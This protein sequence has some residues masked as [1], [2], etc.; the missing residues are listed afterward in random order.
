M[1]AISFFSEDIEF[2]LSKPRKTVAWLKEVI[3]IEGGT[4]SNLNFIFCSDS[5]LHSLNI[6]YL[7]HTT[8]TDIITF[9][10]AENE[11]EIEGDIFISIERV[12]ENAK[13]FDVSFE[14]ELHRVLVHGV[15][16]LLGYNDKTQAQKRAMRQKE[17]SHLSLP[18]VPRET[19]DT[20]K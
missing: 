16:H 3:K 9:D 12:R 15:L 1:P 20:P 14:N 11:G 4:L 7:G 8:L 10:N 17:D 13:K 18:S 2:T 19:K 5:H 6:K